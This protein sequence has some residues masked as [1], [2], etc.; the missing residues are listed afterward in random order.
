MENRIAGDT[1]LLTLGDMAWNHIYIDLH[2]NDI[3]DLICFYESEY[4]EF[5]D[6]LRRDALE[7]Y[8][9]VLYLKRHK[10]LINHCT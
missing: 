5:K 9:I 4:A 3:D 2:Q 1:K 10:I 8:K 6:S 7:Y